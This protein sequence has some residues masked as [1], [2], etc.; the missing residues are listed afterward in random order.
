L[1]YK[2]GLYEQSMKQLN[3]VKVTANSYKKNIFKLALLNYEKNIENQQML[4]LD[5][6][7]CLKLDR[8]TKS[9]INKINVSQSFFSVALI[10]KAHFMKSG[11]V[12]SEDELER[13]NKIFFSNLPDYDKP[14][15]SFSEQYNMC[16]AYY[17]YSYII[18]DFE[19]CVKY[20]ELWVSIFKENNLTHLRHSEFLRGLNRLL[21]SLF[22]INDTD[23][24]NIYYE[25][26][27]EFE[28]L[29]MKA[30]DS[31]SKQLLLR[32][33]TVQTLNKCFL[34]GDYKRH[35]HKLTRYLIKIED[36]MNY[37]DKNNQLVIFY[38]SAILYFGLQHYD[39]CKAYLDRILSDK[40]EH[41]REDLKSFAYLLY[42]I[43]LY[44]ERDFPK[45][46]KMR[47]RAFIYLRQRNI[48]GQ[49]HHI[50]LQFIK[51]SQD[52]MPLDMKTELKNLRSSLEPLA[53]DKFESKT[54]LYFDVMSWLESKISSRPFLDVVKEKAEGKLAV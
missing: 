7:T 29:Y 53:D 40:D 43:T 1:L 44:E 8:E 26:I 19:S 31:D 23:R 6:T 16:R 21:Q 42:V 14:H 10:M 49:F 28:K 2:K 17:W 4:T 48:L 34:D 5:T 15:L 47:K 33:L 51:K 24:F 36:S 22:R 46:E 38:K 54:L 35:E 13:I 52:I 9:I 50:I 25:E 37:I 45:L 30:I 3:K 20:T 39:K 41:L 18:Q 27:L 12:R 11:M 32:C